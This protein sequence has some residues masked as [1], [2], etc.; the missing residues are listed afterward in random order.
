[1][2]EDDQVA[3]I[4]SNLE[5]AQKHVQQFMRKDTIKKQKITKNVMMQS[6]WLN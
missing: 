4:A 3:K 6:S 2:K 1:M 5:I